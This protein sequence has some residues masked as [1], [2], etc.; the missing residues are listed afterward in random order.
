LTTDWQYRALCVQIAKNGYRSQEP[1]EATRESS[2][3]LAMVLAALHQDGV[4]R[5][6]LAKTL[7]I[8]SAELDQLLFGLVMTSIEGGRR[9]GND[10]PRRPSN[11]A[12]TIVK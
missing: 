2:Q 8:N 1:E 11:T 12:L 7:A 3:V 4:G 6:Q 9:S 10:A 5:N